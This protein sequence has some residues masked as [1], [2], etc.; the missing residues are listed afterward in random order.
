M[1]GLA[2]TNPKILH[3][4]HLESGKC[5]FVLFSTAQPFYDP[6]LPMDMVPLSPLGLAS[7]DGCIFRDKGKE[8]NAISAFSKLPVNG[9]TCSSHGT[10]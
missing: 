9:F 8:T 3:L 7:Q 6:R 1:S 10:N 2:F 4:S 5:S